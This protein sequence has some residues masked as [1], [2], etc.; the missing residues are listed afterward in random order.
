MSSR[1]SL[2]FSPYLEFPCFTKEVLRT[3]AHQFRVPESTFHSFIAKGL[4]GGEIIRLKR[5]HYVTRT[6]FE[7]HRTDSSYLFFLA[8]TLLKPSYVSL[9]SALQYYGFFTEAV[10]YAVTS[11]TT[12]LP[13]QFKNKAGIYFYRGMTDT[14]FTDFKMVKGNF[15]FAIALPHKAIFDYLYYQTKQF[16]KNVHANL[17]EEL[18]IDCSE[19]SLPEKENL[20]RLMARYTSVKIFV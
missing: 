20:Q 15:E 12:K 16:T 3:S 9:E 7:K 6:F 11:V 10:N 18:R 19:L 17:L 2:F 5:G 4:K 8:N 14:M 13:R 1:R